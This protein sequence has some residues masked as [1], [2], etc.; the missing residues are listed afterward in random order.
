M[1]ITLAL[2]ARQ[3]CE[4]NETVFGFADRATLLKKVVKRVEAKEAQHEYTEQKKKS[5]PFTRSDVLHDCTRNEEESGQ[6]KRTRQKKTIYGKTKIMA[7]KEYCVDCGTEVGNRYANVFY[8]IV[9]KSAY[10]CWN[11]V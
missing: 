2:E 6:K 4:S 9:I 3:H 7:Y 5:K 8:A 1:H 10:G 11:R